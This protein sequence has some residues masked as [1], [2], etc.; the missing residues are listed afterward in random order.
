MVKCFLNSTFQCQNKAQ[1]LYKLRQD[2]LS[3]ACT[4]GIVQ[5]AHQGPL[6]QKNCAIDESF[7][8]GLCDTD[9]RWLKYIVKKKIRAD[10]LGKGTIS[11]EL[12]V[13]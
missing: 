5:K 4:R 12:L 13:L 11:E 6:S 8:L 7:T 1:L 2:L 3:L 10:I 9:H